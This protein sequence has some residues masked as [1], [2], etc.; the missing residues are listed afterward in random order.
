MGGGA[1]AFPHGGFLSSQVAW[2]FGWRVF[3]L[4]CVQCLRGAERGFVEDEVGKVRRRRERFAGEAYREY[5][6]QG[7][8]CNGW[9]DGNV[10][11]SV[12]LL[13][14]RTAEKAGKVGGS[15]MPHHG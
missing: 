8:Q 15:C 5:G 3:L 14:K 10:M 12:A 6:T 7:G 1:C 13:R 2:P 4:R 11:S 9:M